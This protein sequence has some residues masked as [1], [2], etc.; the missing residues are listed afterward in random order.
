MAAVAV[1]AKEHTRKSI[2]R[3]LYDRHVYATSGERIILDVRADGHIMGSDYKTDKAPTLKIDAVGTNPITKVEIKKDSEI[4]HT[5]E[6][7]QMVVDFTW[8]DPDFD[9]KQEC[10]YYVRVVQSDNEEAISSPIWVN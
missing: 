2:F 10:Y 9:P 4:V 3:A 6:P 5:F 1:Y 8:K 7:V